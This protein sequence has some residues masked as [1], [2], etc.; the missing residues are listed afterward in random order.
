MPNL[1]ISSALLSLSKDCVYFF[2][3]TFSNYFFNT[4]NNKF[5]KSKQRLNVLLLFARKLFKTSSY[6]STLNCLFNPKK[7]L[8]NP[9]VGVW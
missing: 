5:L 1:Y 8:R 6:T 7:R 2:Y 4:L 3:I 9:V